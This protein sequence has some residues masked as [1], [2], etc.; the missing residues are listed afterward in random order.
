MFDY[1]SITRLHYEITS[2]C[3]AKCPMC[4]RFSKDNQHKLLDG[5]IL[6]EMTLEQ[7]QAIFPEEFIKRL[8][9]MRFCGSYG[10]TPIARDYLAINEWFRSV[11]P[12][13]WLTNTTNGSMRK[14]EWWA[15]LA[16]VTAPKDEMSFCIDGIG[17]D[18][19]L[20]RRNTNYEKILENAAAYI[21][22]GGN[23]CWQTLAFKHNQHQ[24]DEMEQIARKMGFNDFRVRA[25]GRFI[26]PAFDVLDREG[27]VTHQ[28]EPTTDPRFVNEGSNKLIADIKKTG[29]NRFMLSERLPISCYAL[30]RE[31]IFVS[32]EG[33]VFP[34]CFT[35]E[36]EIRGVGKTKWEQ[37]ELERLGGR[38]IIDG[39]KYE[40]R[41]IVEGEYFTTI[42]DSWKKDSYEDGRNP[43]CARYCGK[44]TAQNLIFKP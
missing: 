14:P 24:I 11:N 16:R 10:D 1:D 27:N 43:T 20:Y 13:V 29:L 42:Y 28:L 39:T 2:R 18:N 23:A 22:A 37:A 9:K 8:Q 44:G 3:N 26:A 40:L 6:G 35:A 34:C 21:A 32:H 31:E 7:T 25:S 33:L 38:D 36:A 19:A 17:E 5:L 4:G 12:T 30:H 15:E 41:D